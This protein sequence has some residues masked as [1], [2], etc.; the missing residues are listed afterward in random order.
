MLVLILKGTYCYNWT[1]RGY[2]FIIHCSKIIFVYV[3][4]H[5]SFSLP[6]PLSQLFPDLLHIANGRFEINVAICNII[7]NTSTH[8]CNSMIKSKQKHNSST[9]DK[10]CLFV[11]TNLFFPNDVSVLQEEDCPRSLGK[12]EKRC[13]EPLLHGNISKLST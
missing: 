2:I 5:C 13:V 9:L 7:F 8:H 4:V 1:P 6:L 10:Y 11:V 3:L 12:T